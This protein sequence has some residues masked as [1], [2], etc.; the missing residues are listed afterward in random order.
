MNLRSSLSP[1]VLATEPD[2]GIK[3]GVSLTG[4]L[5]RHLLFWFLG[6]ALIPTLFV[7]WLFHSQAL[8][9][10]N[11]NASAYVQTV[12]QLKHQIAENLIRDEAAKLRAHAGSIASVD[13][14][15]ALMRANYLF[16]Q[17]LPQEPLE[18]VADPSIAMEKKIADLDRLGAAYLHELSLLLKDSHHRDVYFIR[19]DGRVLFSQDHPQIMGQYITK[20]NAASSKLVQSLKTLGQQ[21]GVV[22][23]DIGESP[24]VMGKQAGF[25]SQKLRDHRGRF[26]G[27]ISLELDV[28]LFDDMLN[29]DQSTGQGSLTYLMGTDGL[30]RTNLDSSAAYGSSSV[31]L[32]T[33]LLEDW[34]RRLQAQSGAVNGVGITPERGTFKY[35][36]RQ[37]EA[38]IAMYQPVH[39][40][41]VELALVTEMQASSVVVEDF[42]LSKWLIV[43]V[44]GTLIIV[45]VATRIALNNTALPIAV[46]SNWGRDLAR[47]DLYKQ[48]LPMPNNEIRELQ[49]IFN[50]LVESLQQATEVSKSIA[51]GD[52]SREVPV[53]GERDQLGRALL[54][55][56]ETLRTGVSVAVSVSSG[57]FSARVPVKGKRDRFGMALNEMIVSLQLADDQKRHDDWLSVGQSQ[58]NVLLR[59]EQSPNILADY[60]LSMICS[61][62][63]IPIAVMY[64]AD[65]D[66]VQR[67]R[68]VSRYAYTTGR[69]VSNTFEFGEGVVGQAA[70]QR[71]TI[72]MSPV[73]EGYLSV[74]SGLGEATPRCLV[75]VPLVLNGRVVGVMELG[76]F[77][78]F[79]EDRMALIDSVTENIGIAIERARNRESLE[80][81]L[82][83]TRKQTQ[84]L[85]VQREELQATNDFLEIQKREIQDKKIKI[86]VGNQELAEKADEL[87]EASRYKSEFMAN[88]SHELR[89]PL[90]SM[91]ILARD[92]EDNHHHHLDTHE[93]ESARVIGKSGRDLLELINNI[94]DLSKAEAGQM[95]A[96][97]HDVNLDSLLDD[98]KSQFKPLAQDKNLTL[99]FRREPEVPADI[100]T[101]GQKLAQILRNLLSNAIKF[102]SEGEVSLRVHGDLTA[103]YGRGPGDALLFDVADSGIGIPQEK[104]QKVFQAFSQGDGS[105]SRRFG[106]TGLGLSI[107]RGFADLLGGGLALRSVEGE[108]STFTLRL[109]GATLGLMQDQRDSLGL[110]YVAVKE[111]PAVDSRTKNATGLEFE[112]VLLLGST[113]QSEVSILLAEHDVPVRYEL[114]NEDYISALSARDFSSVILDLVSMPR[115]KHDHP[116]LVDFLRNCQQHLEGI[117]PIIVLLTEGPA[118]ELEQDL[119]QCGCICII[120]DG[121]Y[122]ARLKGEIALLVRHAKEQAASQTFA[123][124]VSGEG[125][126]D[127]CLG[128][129][130]QGLKVLIVDDDLR[131]TFALSKL[132]RR[133]GMDV[134]LADNGAMALEKL[135][136]DPDQDVVLMDL[137]MP[138]MDGYQAMEKIRQQSRFAQLPILA[139]TAQTMPEYL[140]KSIQFGASDYLSKPVHVNDL[141]AK[142]RPWLN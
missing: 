66:D 121:D 47:G 137:M 5:G 46:L 109:D 37:G 100:Y 133:C 112:P 98:L 49:N 125:A 64:F 41:G 24:F 52:F 1:S 65:E 129:D 97:R 126:K 35:Y 15:D 113:Q 84:E 54:A 130:M 43:G 13:F 61:Y 63:S 21:G 102:T 132:L 96:N 60:V 85:E 74:E 51:Q 57:D 95:R 99:T 103:M 80:E 25:L 79:G 26:I 62:L 135:E 141:M 87:Q 10:L 22:F 75:A 55:M 69:R 92:L 139:I 104:Q 118:A 34:R 81:L 128:D 4:G 59:E 138:V 78:A 28:T 39:V 76:A 107:S 12:M 56:T 101:D 36:N 91:L 127:D 117:A 38:V 71:K 72:K 6:M 18:A 2:N 134:T 108:G 115:G 16:D 7:V 33:P 136:E 31:R 77:E 82:Q 122:Q 42:W 140:E 23:S 131:N 50:A 105:I 8:L 11:R 111:S 124:L 3:Q 114:W 40:Y 119:E 45:F 83:A 93:V 53:R 19:A 106:G 86:E 44:L 110:G 14:F 68:L 29:D 32:N 67:L 48:N 142:M 123:S 88:M 20:G 58:L 27:F 120:C 89:T 90:N 9:A 116:N 30:K 94:L 17:S 73:P 70:K